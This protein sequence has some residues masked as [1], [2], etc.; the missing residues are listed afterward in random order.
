[1]TYLLC[2]RCQR[3]PVTNFQVLCYACAG[4]PIVMHNV[5]AEQQKPPTP[6]L[7]F[8]RQ[9][10]RNQ[11]EHVNIHKLTQYERIIPALLEQPEAWNSLD[12][13]YHPPRVE[14]LF[15]DVDGYRLYLHVIHATQEL[16][17]FHKHNWPAALK[18]VH[19]SY[20]MGIT[21]SEREISSREAH[22][23]PVLARF[24]I[25]EGSYY[26]MTQTDAM[27]YVRPIT[28]FSL[29][30]MLTNEKYPESAIRTEAVDRKLEP[31]SDL[32]RLEV[33]A[34]FKKHMQ[35]NNP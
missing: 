1:M 34:L 32:R 12:V 33:L 26:E 2:P 31:L 4:N 21:Y 23:L 5:T 16:C 7:P 35:E 11:D 25:A 20:E 9:M 10:K 30:I 22:S 29:S 3:N 13:N 17:L 8:L 19:G 24:I 27:H 6:S 18:Q 28:P 14:R 15:H